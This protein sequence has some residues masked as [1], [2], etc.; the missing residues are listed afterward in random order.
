M[1]LFPSML[2]TGG[3]SR[4]KR[5]VF[6]VGVLYYLFIFIV[7]GLGM[8]GA[9]KLGIFLRKRSDAAKKAAANSQE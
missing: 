3:E 1:I 4:G 7:Y 8:F 6:L 2:L 9:V 5:M